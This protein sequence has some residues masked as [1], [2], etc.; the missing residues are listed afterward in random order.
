[1]GLVIEVELPAKPQATSLEPQ[2]VNRM[3][4]FVAHAE[5]GTFSG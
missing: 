3:T 2:A 5:S 4:F 1:M